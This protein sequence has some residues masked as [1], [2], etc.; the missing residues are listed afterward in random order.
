MHMISSQL[1]SQ[2]SIR[3]SRSKITRNTHKADKPS[4][5]AR[6]TRIREAVHGHKRRTGV[7]GIGIPAHQEET[8]KFT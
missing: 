2:K 7:L 5:L 1:Q 8:E 4:R 6:I 3:I